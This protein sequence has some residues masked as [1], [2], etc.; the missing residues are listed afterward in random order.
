MKN[1]RYNTSCFDLMED[2]RLAMMMGTGQ[3]LLNRSCQASAWP[4]HLNIHGFEIGR[5]DASGE[6]E[7]H[8]KRHVAVAAPR[9]VRS[10]LWRQGADVWSDEECYG[11]RGAHIIGWTRDHMTLSSCGQGLVRAVESLWIRDQSPLALSGALSTCSTDLIRCV[12]MS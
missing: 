10:K 7:R 11:V 12:S 6:Q 5:L 3:V 9:M 2:D 8:R 4:Q 1:T